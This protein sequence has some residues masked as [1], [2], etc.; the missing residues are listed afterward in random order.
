MPPAD[1]ANR[2]EELRAAVRH[3]LHRYHVLDD[4]E[5]SDAEYDALFRELEA[6]EAEHP[7]LVTPDSPT[8]RVGG[9][10][11]D[12]FA[13]VEHRERMFSLDNGRERRFLTRSEVCSIDPG[14]G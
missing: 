5:I 12:A 14:G 4:P 11:S 3:H 1:V 6:V 8:Q 9:P 2:L 13:P 7:E 10:A